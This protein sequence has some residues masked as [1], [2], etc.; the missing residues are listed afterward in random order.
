MPTDT[1]NSDS[2]SRRPNGKDALAGIKTGET[3]RLQ[4]PALN[5]QLTAAEI[6][7]DHEIAIAVGVEP[8]LS[9]ES[10][11]DDIRALLVAEAHHLEG[12]GAGAVDRAVGFLVGVELVNDVNRLSRHAE[13]RH[14]SVVGHDRFVF[15]AGAGD[16]VVELHAEKDFP[17]VAQLAGEFLG[18][19]VKI[20]PLIQRPLEKITK[21]G[22]NR[23]RVIVAQEA[24]A[25]V[26]LLLY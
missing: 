16:Q 2:R 26:D 12:R 4:R 9:R 20:L 6:F 5:D 25:G 21:L 7:H 11:H 22:V 19:P 13:S 23:V 1:W 15:Q 10:G 8:L 17:L 18:H 14:E 24:E 3:P